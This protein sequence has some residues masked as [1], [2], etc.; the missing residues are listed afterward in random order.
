M[1][2]PLVH[3]E[4]IRFGADDEKGVVMGTDGQL[5]I[6]DVADVGEER[7]LVHDEH[8]DDPGLAFSSRGSRRARTSRRRSACSA[9][10]PAR[11]RQRDRAASWRPPP[12]RRARAT[13]HAAA[14]RRHLDRR[15]IARP[16]PVMAAG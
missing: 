2:I 11:V 3:G 8:R 5:R 4:P 6:V 13:C 10:R 1:L 7:I 12:S 16:P 15:L 14:L 9:R